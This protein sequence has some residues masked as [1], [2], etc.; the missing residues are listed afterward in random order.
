[1]KYATLVIG[2]ILMLSGMIWHADRVDKVGT[3]YQVDDYGTP[4]VKE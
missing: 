2:I 1:M 3:F 4:Y